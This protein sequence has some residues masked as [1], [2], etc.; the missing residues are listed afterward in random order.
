MWLVRWSRINAA[1]RSAMP[2]SLV[3]PLSVPMKTSSSVLEPGLVGIWRPSI[4]LPSGI[5]TRL[6]DHEMDAIFAHELCHMRR[7]DNLTAAIHMLVEASFRFYPPVWWLGARLIA[8]REQACNES[9]LKRRS[10]MARL[11]IYLLA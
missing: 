2:L 11:L 6:S 4:L 3:S 5:E 1:I 9:V 7:R 10:R 8:E